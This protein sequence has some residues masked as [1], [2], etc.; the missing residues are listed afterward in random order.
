M[1]TVSAA[2]RRRENGWVDDSKPLVFLFLGSSGVGKTM[3]AKALAEN[4]SHEQNEAGGFIR[5]DMSEYAHKHEVARLIGSPPGYIGH[6][7]GGQLTTK[8][9]ECP[10]AVVL[11]DEVEKA[12]PDV[13][14]LMLQVFDEGRLTDGQGTTID[15]PNAMFIMT[16]NLLQDQI[17]ESTG[18]RPPREECEGSKLGTASLQTS[19]MLAVSAYSDKFLRNV[20]Q[21]VL[22]EHFKRDEFLGRINEM[23]VFHPFSQEDLGDI[24]K[25]EL[26]GWADKARNRHKIRMEWSQG[27]VDRLTQ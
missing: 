4:V 27:V 17:R 9:K 20:V 10:D 2:L 16:S 25:L 22:K 23:I 24:V 13:L 19:T 12:H 3:L 26:N 8:L 7:Q 21:P 5:I 15:C 14:T 1:G 6:D 18:L 11:L